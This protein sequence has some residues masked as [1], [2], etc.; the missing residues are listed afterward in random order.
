[1]SMDQDAW[2]NKTNPLQS[3]WFMELSAMMIE[4]E[5]F[6]YYTLK[7]KNIKIKHRCVH[8]EK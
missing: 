4:C 3:A 2:P 1:M 5:G 7:C 8:A 6:I